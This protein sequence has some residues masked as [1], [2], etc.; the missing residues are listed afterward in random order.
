MIC[1]IV[2][3]HRLNNASSE[4]R[5]LKYWLARSP[6]ERISAVEIL[7]KQHN[8]CSARLRRVARVIKRAKS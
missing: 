4:K 2:K 3:K 5:D 1:K 8:E 7:R 6:D